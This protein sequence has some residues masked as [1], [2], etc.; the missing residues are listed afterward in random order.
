VIQDADRNADRADREPELVSDPD[1][2]CVRDW[3][4]AE[5]PEHRREPKCEDEPI[6]WSAST[7][8]SSPDLDP[9]PDPHGEPDVGGRHG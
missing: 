1:H 3:H 9:E 8:V 7:D 5:A 2:A 4:S 6:R